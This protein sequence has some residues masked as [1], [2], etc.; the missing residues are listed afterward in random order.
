QKRRAEKQPLPKYQDGITMANGIYRPERFIRRSSTFSGT[1]QHSD[2]RDQ[3]RSLRAKTFTQNA[4]SPRQRPPVLFYT[5]RADPRLYPEVQMGL[6]VY[7]R[8]P[9]V[10]RPVFFLDRSGN[11]KSKPAASDT[12]GVTGTTN[13]ERARKD[14]PRSKSFSRSHRPEIFTRRHSDTSETSLIGAPGDVILRQKM[15]SA[16]I[17]SKTTNPNRHDDNNNNNNNNKN[18]FKTYSG[19]NATYAASSNFVNHTPNIKT[20]MN[21]NNKYIPGE[22]YSLPQLQT[23]NIVYP[24]LY[25][26]PASC[27]FL[28]KERGGTI[29]FGEDEDSLSST[30]RKDYPI[31]T[32]KTTGILRQSRTEST[33][34][35]P[36]INSFPLTVTDAEDTPRADYGLEMATQID[37]S[38]RFIINVKEIEDI[39]AMSEQSANNTGEKESGKADKEM[40]KNRENGN[41]KRPPLSPTPGRPASPPFDGEELVVPSALSLS[42]LGERHNT[43]DSGFSQP[44]PSPYKAS[45]DF[46]VPPP[47]PPPPPPPPPPL[48]VEIGKQRPS[49]PRTELVGYEISETEAA[50]ISLR[51]S[52]TGKEL[53]ET[54]TAAENQTKLVQLPF[55]EE[56]KRRQRSIDEGVSLLTPAFTSTT[57]PLQGSSSDSNLRRNSGKDNSSNHSDDLSKSESSKN[58]LTQ[59]PSAVQFADEPPEIIPREDDYSIPAY[60]DA[61]D[62]RDIEMNIVLSLSPPLPP[63]PPPLPLHF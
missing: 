52:S 38:E 30:P 51:K 27:H 8:P 45:F 32:P 61:E 31:D 29:N 25:K 60:E 6:P 37:Y 55:M 15:D 33:E 12:V 39:I 35:P 1:S 34:P 40:A 47:F 49:T 9:Q 7:S 17:Y 18:H 16:I 62:E 14:K 4:Q 26:P 59:R 54:N 48:L 56:L 53:P 22:R 44:I 50:S 58:G 24:A 28:Y 23:S 5:I 42:S 2:I 36:A 19:H 63:P 21:K 20:Y 3:R 43:G 10:G 13:E 46:Q 11:S 41:I 57:N